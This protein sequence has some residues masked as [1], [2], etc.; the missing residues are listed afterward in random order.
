MAESPT[1]GLPLV[2]CLMA[3]YGRHSLTE[4]ALACFLRQDYPNAELI[5]LNNHAVRMRIDPALPPELAAKIRLYNEPCYATLGACR[6]RLLDLARGIF[7]RTW[8]TDDIYMPWSIRQGWEGFSAASQTRPDIPA[9]KPL[10]SWWTNGGKVFELAGNAMEAS[11]LIRADV[12]RKFGYQESGGDEHSPLLAGLAASGGIAIDDV[13]I[14]SGYCYTWG[15]G[16]HHISGTL[17]SADSL[18][19]RTYNWMM[20]Q[21]DVRLATRDERGNGRDD[22][23]GDR[24]PAILSPDYS[25]AEEFWGK[26][27]AAC[28]AEQREFMMRCRTGQA[29]GH[30]G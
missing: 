9:W 11:I 2:S 25:A 23:N 20:K 19:V 18:A 13:G 3:T 26:I 21:T 22:G 5:I 27:S 1:A 24:Q 30:N 14:W 8:D 17:N 4:R 28:G 7:I 12:A 29:A 16:Q 6:N 10:K 15:M